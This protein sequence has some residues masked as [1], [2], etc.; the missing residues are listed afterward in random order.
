MQS[1]GLILGLLLVSASGEGAAGANDTFTRRCEL[2]KAPQ[3]VSWMAAVRRHGRSAFNHLDASYKVFRNVKDF[4]AVGD[5]LHD[6]TLAINAAISSG[7][8]CGRDCG[9]SGTSTL[10]PALVFLPAG[11]YLISSSILQYYHTQ[12]V[13]DATHPP[14]IVAAGGDAWTGSQNP[15][16]MIDSNPPGGTVHDGGNWWNAPDNF[17]RS[18]RNLVFDSRRVDER[19]E[20]RCV[21]WQV[22]QA[23]SLTGLVFKMAEGIGSA[24]VGVWMES[25]SGGWMADLAFSGGGVGIVAGNQQFT[26]ARMTFAGVGTAVRVVWDWAWA[27]KN[28]RVER[29]GVAFD[30]SKAMTASVSILD[31]VIMETNVVVMTSAPLPVNDSSTGVA[32]PGTV[33]LDNIEMISVGAAVLHTASGAALLP[34]GTFH[35]ERWG[36]GHVYRNGSRVAVAGPLPRSAKPAALL[37]DT[38]RFFSR[39]RPEYEEHDAS[40]FISVKNFGAIGDGV[41][42]D[43]SAFQRAIDNSVGCKIVFI[44]AGAYLLTATIRVPPH[45]RMVG[46]AWPLL[47]ASGSNFSDPSNP[48]PLLRAGEPGDQG[49]LELS[50]LLLTTRGP[51]PGV[52]LLQWNIRDRPGHQGEC[53]TWDVHTR[54]G[55]AAGSLM[56]S[57]SCPPTPGGAPPLP[58]C[59]G[60]WAHAHVTRGASAYFENMWLWTA[61][62]DLDAGGAVNVYSGRGLMI[63]SRSGPVW[64]LG[65]AAEHSTLYQYQIADASNVFASMIQ[66]ETP[67]YQG[68]LGPRAVEPFAP[69]AKFADPTFVQCG[70]VGAS[71]AAD[72]AMSWALRI[73]RSTG[74]MV[75]GAGLYSF[76]KNHDGGCVE[77]YCQ[78]AMV[79]IDGA[80]DVDLVA[81]NTLGAREILV[82][83]EGWEIGASENVEVAGGVT[84]SGAL[85]IF[86]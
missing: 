36:I 71:A 81:I 86:L 34:G 70:G 63:T 65:T 46:E 9:A 7:N 3:A 38:G 52:L 79:S 1:L 54:V 11:T 73:V 23:T 33:I 49:P 57:A 10:T 12:L 28:V 66:T 21:H 53:G 75:Y 42:D 6:D 59:M 32:T 4:G 20:I 5:G 58:S 56:G 8:R 13:G 35:V 45:T 50:D 14:T 43:T 60:A 16:V 29:C 55:G 64:L 76:F 69:N 31:S 25:G 51:A 62:H 61:D 40:D 18:V 30:L 37:D 41:A 84:I 27:F 39:K 19:E 82:S 72:C 15:R 17:Y 68:G 67:Y 77:G 83:K 74:V 44:P 48:H 26:S 2:K 22:G 47:M 24:H 80:T 78:N 85:A